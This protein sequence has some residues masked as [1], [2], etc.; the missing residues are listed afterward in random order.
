M[1]FD[2]AFSGLRLEIRR[3]VIDCQSHGSPP[4]LSSRRSGRLRQRAAPPEHF[5]KALTR[6]R[7]CLGLALTF[8]RTC[9]QWCWMAKVPERPRLGPA[10]NA[11]ALKANKLGGCPPTCDAIKFVSLWLKDRR[12]HGHEQRL[13]LRIFR[14]DQ[15]RAL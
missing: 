7:A 13:L 11:D 8:E 5:R 10:R 12:H 14:E 15:R 2:L 9:A 3:G 6:H 4:E 1:E